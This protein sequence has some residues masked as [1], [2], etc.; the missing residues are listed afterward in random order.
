MNMRNDR[1]SSGR[2][3]PHPDTI[4]YNAAEDEHWRTNYADE[5]YHDSA[6]GFE[7]YIPAYRLGY[8]GRGRYAGQRWEEV[9]AEMRTD[10][11][12]LRGGSRMDWEEAAPAARAGWQRREQS[13]FV[14]DDPNRP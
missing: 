2:V 13:Y 1:H 4:T 5:P 9:E 14:A 11:P 7:D 3:A 10:W 6:F 12:M 8:E